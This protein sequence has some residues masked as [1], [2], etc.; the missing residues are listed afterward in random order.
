MARIQTLVQLDDQLVSLLDQRASKEGLSRSALIRRAVE[1]Y[2]PE[3]LEAAMDQAIVA[4]YRALPPGE[5]PSDLSALAA[6][7][8]EAEPW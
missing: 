2:L 4:G 7:S 1:A 5:P 8:I 3:D 6:A